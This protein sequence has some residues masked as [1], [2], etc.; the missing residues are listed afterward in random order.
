M[1]VERV[2]NRN[3]PPA[4][5]LRSSHW[6][7]G[8]IRKVTHANLSRLPDHIT[9]AIALLLRGGT[10]V[11]PGSPAVQIL[12]SRPF[13]HVAALLAAARKLDLPSLL[14]SRPGRSRNLALALVLMRL[15]CPASR[16]GTARN[17]AP[18]A[19]FAALNEALDLGPISEHHVEDTLDWLARR[20]PAIEAKLARRHLGAGR[21]ALYSLTTASFSGAHWQVAL[22]DYYR[23][24]R[25][26]RVQI[27]VGLLCDSEGCPISAETCFGHAADLSSVASQAG[28]IRQRFGLRRVVLIENR[29]ALGSACNLEGLVLDEGFGRISLL[30]STAVR[31]LLRE[32]GV[33]PLRVRNSEPAQIESASYPGE[34]LLIYRDPTLKRNQRE[35]REALLQVT[36]VALEEICQDARRRTDPLAGDVL[37]GRVEQALRQYGMNEHFRVEM[38]EDGLRWHRDET[39][40]AA[41]AAHDGLCALRAQVPSG[42][43]DNA[44]VVRASRRQ[45]G[46]ERTYRDLARVDIEPGI[47]WVEHPE[48][49][50]AYGLVCL[51]ACYLEWHLRRLLAPLL[52]HDDDGAPVDRRR[53]T[54]KASDQP[55]PTPEAKP[56]A[57]QTADEQSPSDVRGLLRE[58]G[59]LS[60]HRVRIQPQEDSEQLEV[61]LL[62]EANALQHR[63]FD[64]LRIRPQAYLPR[65][66][67][68]ARLP[69]KA[70]SSSG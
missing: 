61:V 13:G 11:G 2:P 31:R 53:A 37:N 62:T 26:G 55:A 29:A 24:D 14:H 46:V 69:T 45:A 34:R 56:G 50:Q 38:G 65:S 57:R 40:L 59:K 64:L 68:A 5:L 67:A 20:R 42:E 60:R 52:R 23:D 54:P 28:R 1:Y 51:L 44:G 39:T 58:L 4:V 43:L 49:L 33:V 36:E 12:D 47:S 32:G 66:A 7:R 19:E 41:H 27:P 30:R 10:V 63:A 70:G 21:H 6:D 16:P 17:L 22:S 35:R 3:S 25:N 8:K 48:R 9:D 18:D 15:L